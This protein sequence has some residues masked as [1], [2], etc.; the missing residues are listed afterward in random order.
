[1]EK[2]AGKPSFFLGVLKPSILCLKLKF[3]GILFTFLLRFRYYKII[4]KALT[5]NDHMED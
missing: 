3:Y 5:K 2:R 4:D 1:M